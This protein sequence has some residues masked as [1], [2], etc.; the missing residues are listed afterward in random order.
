[1]DFSRTLFLCTSNLTNFRSF[2]FFSGITYSSKIAFFHFLFYVL[3]IVLLGSKSVTGTTL[4]VK[5]LF[6]IVKLKSSA[7]VHFLENIISLT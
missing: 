1:M 3:R 4:S 2:I 6:P 5:E 7:F